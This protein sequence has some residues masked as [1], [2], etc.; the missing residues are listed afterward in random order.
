[1]F[2]S[3]RKVCR[4]AAVQEGKPGNATAILLCKTSAAMSVPARVGRIT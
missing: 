3:S 1:M 2:S 4:G